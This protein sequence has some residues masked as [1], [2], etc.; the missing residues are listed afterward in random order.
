MKI[1]LL[2]K[3]RAGIYS[4]CMFIGFIIL[5]V[6]GSYISSAQGNTIEYPNPF[7]SPLLGTV[8]YMAFAVLFGAAVIG[9]IAVLKDKER[10]ILVYFIIPTGMVVT[11]FGLMLLVGGLIGPPNQ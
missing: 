9:V 6:A 10:S 11:L 2:P 1:T 3:T 7:N 4:V 5:A 8:I